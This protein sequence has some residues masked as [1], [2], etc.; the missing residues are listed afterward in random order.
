MPKQR[1]NDYKIPVSINSLTTPPGPAVTTTGGKG[2][3]SATPSKRERP[4]GLE[5]RASTSSSANS[6]SFLGPRSGTPNRADGVSAHTKFYDDGSARTDYKKI[7]LDPGKSPTEQNLTAAALNGQLQ[8]V[9]SD[10]KTAKTDSHFHPTNYSQRGA[11]FGQLTAMMDQLGVRNTTLMPIPTSIISPIEDAQRADRGNHHCGEAYYI[12]AQFANLRSNEMTPQIAAQITSRTELVMDTQVDH[13]LA[14]RFHNAGMSE[15]EKSR[16]DPMVTGTHLGSPLAPQSLVEKMLQNKG[17]FTGI[18]EVTIHKEL[19]GEMFAG[20]AQANLTTRV[21]SFK[22]LA[23][24]AGVIG[25]PMVLHCDV[26]TLANNANRGQEGYAPAHLNALRDL[27]SS[28]E[29]ANTNV[30]WAHG[31]GL[32]R[33]V[34]EPSAAHT[35]E[36]NRLLSDNPKLHIDI[37]WS[38]VATQLTNPEA[39]DRWVNLI[40]AH[41]DRF[42]IGSDSLSPADESRWNETFN[43]YAEFL[44]RLQP[45]TQESLLNG[46]YERVIVDSRPKVRE[47]EEKVLTDNFERTQLLPTDGPRI[48]AASLNEYM[49]ANNIQLAPR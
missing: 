18:G 27:F 13:S 12:P 16:F 17:T 39:I 40:E 30:I 6:A 47:F 43:L 1:I 44:D 20:D 48:T 45:S 11:N 36:L 7:K 19:V 26:D 10:G 29:L 5:S 14:Y 42:L 2:E 28:N 15:A 38:H 46:N 8:H 37:S 41:P 49:Q 24:V 21:Q 23:A 4:E 34:Q 32:G 22:D 33:F 25:M 9:R 35:D 31:G 3:S